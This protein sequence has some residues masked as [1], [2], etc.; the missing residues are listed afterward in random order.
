MSV[1][2]SYKKQFLFG[3]LLCLI[4]I[5]GIEIF[6]RVYDYN[7]P[8]CS[9]YGSDVFAELSDNL[10]RDICYSNSKLIWDESPLRLQPLQNLE[11]THINSE[12]FRGSEFRDDS[13]SRIFLIGGSTMFGVGSSSDE[14][15][16]PGFF[17][18]YVSEKFTDIEIINAGIPGADSFTE[19]EYIEN[20]LLEYNPKIFVIYDGWNDLQ[21][22]FKEMSDTEENTTVQLIRAINRGEYQTP[23]ILIQHYFNWKHNT[24]DVTFDTSNIN[25]KSIAWKNNWKKTCN[26][27]DDKGIK[28]ILILQPILGSGNKVLSSEEEH[29]YS[30]YDSK[31]MNE[32]YETYA[33]QLNE[34]ED[35]C[36]KVLDYRDTFDEFTET[37]FFD[38][39]HTGDLGNKIVAKRIFSDVLPVISSNSE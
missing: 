35:S 4:I 17:E 23:K 33:E 24:T 36:T 14:T 22:D 27:L 26:D 28:T 15:T 29:Y 16:I 6:L 38:S 5:S 9:F 3:V 18:V 39:G 2:I 10:K 12:G 8:A 31:T 34:L 20:Q 7:Y 37:L 25:E 32:Y 21:K 11:T 19:I 13:S 30:H 1:Q